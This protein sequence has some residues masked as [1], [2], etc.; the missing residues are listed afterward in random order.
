MLDSFR[1]RGKVI[2]V[3]LISLYLPGT[4]LCF[5]FVCTSIPGILQFSILRPGFLC[6]DVDEWRVYAF[7]FLA[8]LR[9][10]LS[11]TFCFLCIIKGLPAGWDVLLLHAVL[12]DSNAKESGDE[13]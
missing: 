9:F 12:V 1:G 7:V 8:D 10:Q 11:C 2:F 6:S 3:C 13:C 5:V 4:L